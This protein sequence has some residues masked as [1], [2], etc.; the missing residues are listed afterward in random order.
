MLRITRNDRSAGRN[1]KSQFSPTFSH[2]F[3]VDGNSHVTEN[4]RKNLKGPNVP[5]W[6]IDQLQLTTVISRSSGELASVGRP[7][8]PLNWIGGYNKVLTTR[9]GDGI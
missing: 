3:V 4:I 1:T 7:S 6:K 2:I 5:V 9:T 8:L